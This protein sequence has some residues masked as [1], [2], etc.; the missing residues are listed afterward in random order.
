MSGGAVPSY[1]RIPG[2]TRRASRFRLAFDPGIGNV[3]RLAALSQ[4]G[5]SSLERP[6]R[7]RYH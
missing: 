6:H 3:F 5:I 4:R 1:Y 7:N 2:L